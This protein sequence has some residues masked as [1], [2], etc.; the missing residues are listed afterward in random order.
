[1]FEHERLSDPWMLLQEADTSLYGGNYA[2]ART[3][4]EQALQIASQSADNLLLWNALGTMG[5]VQ[6]RLSVPEQVL[7]FYL[8]S[9][10][11]AEKAQDY[12]GVGVMHLE[13]GALSQ[14]QGRF[15]EAQRRYQLAEPLLIQDECGQARLQVQQGSLARSQGLYADA[16]AFLTR[17]LDHAM[18]NGCTREALNARLKLGI[19]NAQEGKLMAAER[20]LKLNLTAEQALGDKQGR[21]LALYEQAGDTPKV[22]VTLFYTG[23]M[24]EQQGRLAEAEQLYLQSEQRAAAIGNRYGVA[25]AT[26]GRA[27]VY[28][29]AGRVEEA[30]VFMSEAARLF[31]E[32]GAVGEAQDAQQALAQ[33]RTEIGEAVWDRLTRKYPALK[34]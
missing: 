33:F 11:V 10:T 30:C 22:V 17:A 14:E 29:G 21:A 2:S 12:A 16:D 23:Q 27:S 3:V 28:W 8:Q 19:L 7:N 34:F 18:A 4:A 9:Q 31:Q 25:N 15:E 32:Q 6:R 5:R 20:M 13:I 26:A 24:V 1:M